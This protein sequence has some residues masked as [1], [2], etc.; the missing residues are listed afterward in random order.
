MMIC[1]KC[2]TIMKH[3]IRFSYDYNCELDVCEKCHFESRP[4]RLKFDSIE[5]M[6]DNTKK[7]N[8]LKVA[9]KKPKSGDKKKS[10]KKHKKGKNK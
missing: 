6:Q 7:K 5:I 10:N 8:K 1:P 9:I 4:R 3:V 2:H